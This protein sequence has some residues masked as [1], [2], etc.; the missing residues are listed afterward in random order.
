MMPSFG[1]LFLEG[2]GHRDAVEHRVHGHAGQQL[3][4]K[5][6]NAELLVGAQNLGIDFVQALRPIFLGF[7]AE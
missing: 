1:E 4:L 5:Q 2:G 3:L 6:R 7:G